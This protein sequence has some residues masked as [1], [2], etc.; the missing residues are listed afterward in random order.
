VPA[1]ED[2]PWDWSRPFD[3]DFVASAAVR[4]QPGA[5]RAAQARR[6]SADHDRAAAWRSPPTNLLPTRSQ[7]RRR[8]A[9]LTL[10]VV[11][12][13][14]LALAGLM[15]TGRSA[16]PA[17]AS[18]GDGTPRVP[19]PADAQQQRGLP[20]VATPAGKGGYELLFEQAGRP[21]L[22]DPCRPIHWVMRTAGAPADGEALLLDGFATL[23]RA[24]GLQ[25]RYDGQT[26]EA[27]DEQ[28]PMVQR[29]RYGNRYAPVL[30]VW[31]DPRESRDLE[32]SVGGFAAP[33][34]G[35]PDGQGPRLLTGAVVL[36]AP[37]L[38]TLRD[39]AGPVG[40]VLHELG[41]M[42]GLAH[43]DDP[44]DSMYARSG[45]ATGYTS[46]ALRGLAA[47]GR[48]PCFQRS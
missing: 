1:S 9:R 43:V 33:Q 5:A 44:H 11:G 23:S 20:A 4:E 34:G 15:L 29:D 22:F 6:I 25:F 47:V 21:V 48:G 38:A 19:V 41:H 8:G 24:T 45:P 28:R 39:P 10:A 36:D 12:A 32:G 14:L 40:V 18:V 31:S 13:V 2:G 30:V 3:E 35:D 26:D 42:V 46:G 17:P 27:Y 16:L 37:Q 7:R